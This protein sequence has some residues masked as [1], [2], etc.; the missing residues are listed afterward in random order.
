MKNKIE[1]EQEE[2]II[3]KMIKEKKNFELV[4][5]KN[6]VAILVGFLDEDDDDYDDDLSYVFSEL[7]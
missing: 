1:N 7:D 2:K 3:E 5:E 4:D 6:K